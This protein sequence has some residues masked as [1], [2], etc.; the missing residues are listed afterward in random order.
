V[1][2]DIKILGASSV[3]NLYADFELAGKIN[4]KQFR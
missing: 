3:N 2:L 4:Q 1:L